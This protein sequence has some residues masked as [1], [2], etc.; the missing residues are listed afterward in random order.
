MLVKIDVS[1][2][3]KGKAKLKDLDNYIQHVLELSGEGNDIILMG[4][5]PIWLYLKISHALHGKARSLTYWSP[6]TGEIQI[7]N[8]DPY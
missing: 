7:F 4:P 8:H 2:L 6:V 3:Y 1:G 5:G